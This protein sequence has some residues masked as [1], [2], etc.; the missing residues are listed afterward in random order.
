M[1]GAQ[2]L[3]YWYS[4]VQSFFQTPVESTSSSYRSQ[5]E[6]PERLKAEKSAPLADIMLADAPDMAIA[7]SDDLLDSAA[8][9]GSTRSPMTVARPDG[10]GVT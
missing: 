5:L 4:D 6:I 7:E 1:Y 8:T 9:P 3:D 2:G 10:I